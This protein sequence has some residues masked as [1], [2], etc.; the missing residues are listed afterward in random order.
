MNRTDHRG[1]GFAIFC[2]WVIVG[3][4]LGTGVA[5]FVYARQTPLFESVAVVKVSRLETNTPTVVGQF[6]SQEESNA[7]AGE[8]SETGAEQVSGV[9]MT[10][11]E[12]QDLLL[13]D[14]DVSKAQSTE[15]TAGNA[16]SGSRLSSG[17]SVDDRLLL[18][19][20]A[21]LMR[22]VELGGLT[23]IQ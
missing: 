6:G 13:T 23:K 14:P 11:D 10:D 15:V 12:S 16:S 21:V 7:E 19:S 20:Q 1:R 5:Y 4:L 18:G 22:A 8:T 17:V 9:R 2:L 3:V